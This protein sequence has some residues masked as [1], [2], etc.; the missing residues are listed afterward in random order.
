MRRLNV[1]QGRPIQSAGGAWVRIEPFVPAHR[2][3]TR[4]QVRHR[5]S[6]QGGR[7]FDFFDRTARS[8]ADSAFT[9]PVSAAFTV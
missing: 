8:F 3:S 1:A 6:I 2:S 5:G 9:R 4:K 7:A